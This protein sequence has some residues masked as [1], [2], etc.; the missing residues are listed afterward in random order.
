MSLLEIITYIVIF[1][2][3]RKAV[4]H[5]QACEVIVL[6]TYTQIFAEMVP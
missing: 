6:S 4:G 1:E 3:N 2:Q 5:K